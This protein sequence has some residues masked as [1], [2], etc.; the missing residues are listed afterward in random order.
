MPRR[1]NTRRNLMSLLS[2]SIF[3][4]FILSTTP[5]LVHHLFD[6]SPTPPCQVYAIA[7]S[8]HI[9]PVSVTTLSPDRFV[10]E[11]TSS[12]SLATWIPYLDPSPFSQRAPPQA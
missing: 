2:G 5:H 7:K 3:I 1:S 6:E 10:I 11:K 8:C 12:V 9:Q 4:Y